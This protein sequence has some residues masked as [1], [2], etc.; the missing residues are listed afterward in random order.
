[1]RGGALCS[2][3]AAFNALFWFHCYPK[4]I[5]NTLTL[6][7]SLDLENAYSS[8]NLSNPNLLFNLLQQ[9][10]QTVVAEGQEIFAQW[11]SHIEREAFCQSGQ[12]LAYYLALRRQELRPLQKALMPWGISSLGRIES[13][14]LP[15][16]DA[17]IASLGA[18]CR[19]PAAELPPH[20]T[21]E[22]FYAGD[23][24]LRQHTA[25]VFGASS[26]ERRVRIMVTLPSEAADS[27]AFIYDL[28][29]AGINCV[30]INCAHDNPTTWAAMIDHLRHAEA[31]LGRS[32]RVLMDLA[33]PKPRTG[34]VFTPDGLAHPDHPPRIHGGD[35]IHLTHTAVSALPKHM[36]QTSCTLPEVLDQ[37]QVGTAV[38]INDGRIGCE[39]EECVSDGVVLRVIHARP[40]GEK[41]RP[42]KGLNFPDT[43]VHISPLTEKD[44]HDLDFVATHADIIGYS[45]VQEASDIRLLQRELQQRLGDAARR[46]AI[47]AKIETPTAIRNLPEMIVQAAGQQPFGVMIARGDLAV[48]IGYQR[49]A[50]MQEEILWLCEAANVPVIWATQVFENLVKKGIPSRAEVTDAAMAERAECV[51]LNKGP[52]LAEGVRV[53][54]DVLRR[55]EEHQLKKTSRLRPLR[56][57]V[58]DAEL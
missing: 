50:E 24:L 56:S 54:D 43:T 44:R 57:W 46:V 23:R 27:G 37:L 39:V 52:H 16:L 11:R 38:W 41:L 32:C 42:D 55:M 5:M 47:V 34:E 25:D 7:H 40:T 8:F 36:V 19:L 18:I 31:K 29:N 12:N 22:E 4:N 1:M 48:E 35:R 3:H 51:M 28:V 21:A 17:A 6:D 30:R 26:G 45:F 33:G 2:V 53:L 10:R 14:V 20:P 58:A 9:L 15:N 13:R 49:L